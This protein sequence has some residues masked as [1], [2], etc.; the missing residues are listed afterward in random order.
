MNFAYYFV[1]TIAV[2]SLIR[3]TR[4]SAIDVTATCNPVTVPLCMTSHRNDEV[5]PLWRHNYTVF[6]SFADDRSPE[7][8]MTSLNHMH[9]L[10]S[11]SCSRYL[12]LY[13]CAVHSPACTRHGIAPPCRELCEKVQSDCREVSETFGIRWPVTCDSF[14]SMRASGVGR[15][16]EGAIGGDMYLVSRSASLIWAESLIDDGKVCI[17]PSD[18][19]VINPALIRLDAEQVTNGN[20]TS[21]GQGRGDFDV[22]CP[23]ELRAPPFHTGYTF[24]DLPNC[25]APCPNMY[26][27]GMEKDVLRGYVC[28]LACL[29]LLVTLFALFTFAIDRQRFRYPER[30][31][32]F[33]A[34]SY[35]V[36]SV[37]FLVGFILGEE[38]SCNNK[39]VN[40]DNEIIQGHAVVVGAHRRICTVLFMILYYFTVNGAIWW[41]ILTITWLLA[42]GFKWGSEAIEKH[43]LHY[44]AVAWSL[45]A[46]QTLVVI[47]SNKIEGDN[48]TGVCFV[49]VYDSTGLRYLLLA[50]MCV[51]LLVGI[52]LLLTG[53][54]CL[55]RV[56]KSLQDDEENKKKLAKFMLRIGVFSVMFI[57]PQMCLIIIFVVEDMNRSRWEAAWYVRSCDHYAV[58]CPASSDPVGKL[59]AGDPRPHFMLFMVKYTMM[60][61]VALPPLFW[62]T[63]KKTMKSWKGFFS[64]VGSS[65]NTSFNT[66]QTRLLNDS[67]GPHAKD[68]DAKLVTQQ[69]AKDHVFG[70]FRDSGLHGS[71]ASVAAAIASRSANDRQTRWDE[72]TDTE[73]SSE[74]N[75]ELSRAIAYDMRMNRGE[76]VHGRR[77]AP[78]AGRV[79][80]DNRAEGY[81]GN[82]AKKP[83]GSA[84]GDFRRKIVAASVESNKVGGAQCDTAPPAAKKSSPS[85]A[86]T[87]V[88]SQN[89]I[90]AKQISTNSGSSS[91]ITKQSNAGLNV[92]LPKGGTATSSVRSYTES[93]TIPMPGSTAKRFKQC[94]PP[95]PR[96]PPP[97][98]PPRVES[99]KPQDGAERALSV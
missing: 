58:P 34:F 45:P 75:S 60:L 31:I 69:T 35:F 91:I 64:N 73:F 8:V 87:T 38:A 42:A 25:T 23:A 33:Y 21:G 93:D 7:D 24:M 32:I 43:W 22:A 28:A 68:R 46:I 82:H 5:T 79:A 95:K 97:L 85:N 66:T 70:N 18:D 12:P 50:P 1:T 81:H 62:V 40:A 17:P 52:I 47:I 55:N 20:A 65:N 71:S 94:A 76:R 83:N 59:A 61:I 80:K 6:P 49:G 41:L 36:V 86:P 19:D 98:P 51:Y 15:S 27:E 63:S 4:A 11:T 67:N 77:R 2:T 57:I 89:L 30:P 13:L 92:Q 90:V 39:V 84:Q 99:A 56:R 26:M 74:T 96:T 14:P 72:L 16:G 48:I 3:H 37:V 88:T 78:P 10:I 44:H 53:F 9:P 54:F 29:S